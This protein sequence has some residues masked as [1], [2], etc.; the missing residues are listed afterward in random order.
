MHTEI[1]NAGAGAMVA[2][3]VH[4]EQWRDREYTK[5]PVWKKLLSKRLTRLNRLG[6]VF[7]A[8][9]GRRIA[10][11]TYWLSKREILKQGWL[12]DQWDVHNI[13][14]EEGLEYILGC[15]LDGSTTQITAWYLCLIDETGG[16]PDG[17]ETYAVPVWVELTTYDEA[18]RITWV[19]AAITGTSTKSIANT[20]TPAVFTISATDDYYG[21]GMVGGGGAA[22]TKD[23]QAGGGTLFS[24]AYFGS[25][26]SLVDNDTL[27]VTYTFTATDAG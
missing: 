4:C 16:A 5:I 26:K 8:M 25:A 11:A 14:S 6:P 15:G 19:D 27:T 22:S 12:V 10:R 3:M 18:N 7:T 1:T 9:F 24:S 17:S 13:V 2:G 23:D 20:G 21:V